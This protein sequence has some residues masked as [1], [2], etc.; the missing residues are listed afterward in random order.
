MVGAEHVGGRRHIIW[1]VKWSEPKNYKNKIYGG[2]NCPPIGEA[3]HSN[4]PKIRGNNGGVVKEVVR[5]G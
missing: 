5:P 3:T 2:L 1:G 4:H